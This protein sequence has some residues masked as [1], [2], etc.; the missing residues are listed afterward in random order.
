MAD[1]S[2]HHDNRVYA[3][4]NEREPLLSGNYSNGSVANHLLGSSQPLS[5]KRRWYILILFSM[6]CMM[7]TV[8]WN[9]WGPIA[10]SAK[11]AYGWT[12]FDIFLL[13][14]W[15]TITYLIGIIGFTWLL[16]VKGLR[17]SVIVTAALVAVAGGL[18]C[19]STYPRLATILIHTSA[20]LNG[21]AGCVVMSAPTL[22]S[23]TW[24]PLEQRTTATAFA[25]V[26]AGMG[27]SLSFVIGPLWVPDIA[28]CGAVAQTV[29]NSRFKSL[30]PACSETDSEHLRNKIWQ[31]MMME[32]IPCVLV[33]MLMLIYFPAKPPT[34]PSVTAGAERLSYSDGIRKLVRKYQ[35]W[36]LC[37]PYAVGC[38]GMLIWTSV[39]EVILARLP[40]ID[41]SIAGWIGFYLMLGANLVGIVIGLL[42]DKLK[43]QLKAMLIVLFGVGGT[44]LL[45]YCLMYTGVIPYS[46]ALLYVTVITGSIL[47]LSSTPLFLELACETSYPIAEGITTGVLTALNNVVALVFLGIGMIKALGVVWMNWWLIAVSFLSI[48]VFLVY[49]VS[50]TRLNID[51]TDDSV[52]QVRSSSATPD[53][54]H[55]LLS[56]SVQNSARN[57]VEC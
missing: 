43:R 47:I 30:F 46:E 51:S 21:F 53:C 17:V 37:I 36:L 1:R 32:F 52:T 23:A 15:G 56:G 48:P 12:D 20:I 4:N 9:N 45:V 41:Q 11:E 28:T 49:K 22:L 10:E 26:M 8:I 39:M 33:L 50:Y 2:W 54:H 16:D 7:Q 35:F 38:G 27:L 3:I 25:T 6:L 24:F 44:F 13:P 5:Y 57:S 14:N 29:R 18:R 19:L 55:N 42:A 40:G 31:L 34:P